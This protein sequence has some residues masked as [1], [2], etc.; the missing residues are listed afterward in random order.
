M[1]K[2]RQKGKY[3]LGEFTYVGSLNRRVIDR[4]C[5][6]YSCDIAIHHPCI[7]DHPIWFDITLLDD[8]IFYPN[9]KAALTC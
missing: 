2:C 4:G 8:I 5:N 9:S 1:L 6:G 7:V 3:R